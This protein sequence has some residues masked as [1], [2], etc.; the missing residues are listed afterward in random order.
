MEASH[1]IDEI[2]DE[3][4]ENETQPIEEDQYDE[5][6]ENDDDLGEGDSFSKGSSKKRKRNKLRNSSNSI[7]AANFHRYNVLAQQ[8]YV[9]DNVY[10]PNSY[11]DNSSGS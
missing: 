1:I 11:V 10:N 4:S 6:D 2:R 3:L 8:Q 9:Q 5:L 7:K